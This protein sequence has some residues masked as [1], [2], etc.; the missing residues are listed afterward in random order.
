MLNRKMLAVVMIAFSIV[1]VAP[2]ARALE[3]PDTITVWANNTKYAPGDTGHLFIVFYNRLD[4][5]VEIKNISIVYSSWK[6][7]I[8]NVWV[9]NET[10]KYTDQTAV[11][12]MPKTFDI[13][14]TVP[15][16]GR[17]VSTNAAIEIGTDHG[18]YRG[19]LFA[20]YTIYVPETPRYMEQIVSILT[21]QMVALIVCLII[22][23][24]TIFISSRRPKM[25]WG[26]ED[27]N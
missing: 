22:L 25:T 27:K 18:I 4:E 20:G 21:I 10:H 14:F 9:G 17:G 16:D 13:P 15:S 26:P 7:Y 23:A 1:L 3:E 12:K 19:E 5:A 6:A 2:L 11:S 8:N 24:A